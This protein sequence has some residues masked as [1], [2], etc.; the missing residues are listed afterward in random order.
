MG[1]PIIDSLIGFTKDDLEPLFEKYVL[2]IY[3]F[4]ARRPN[5]DVKW[6][7][8]SRETGEEYS[9]ERAIKD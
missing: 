8:I 4:A 1:K 6:Q 9:S 3:V 2:P 7:V 5:E